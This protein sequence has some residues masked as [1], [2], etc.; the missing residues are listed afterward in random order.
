MRGV[1]TR[2]AEQ[3]VIDRHSERVRGAEEL[4]RLLPGRPSSARRLS[5]LA[6]GVLR[7]AADRLDG[8]P[9]MEARIAGQ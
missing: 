6:A 7:A 5:A 8:R 1:D 3:W 4:A 9:A 2:I